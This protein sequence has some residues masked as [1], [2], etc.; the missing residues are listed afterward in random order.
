MKGHAGQVPKGLSARFSFVYNAQKKGT[1]ML[2]H[3]L[4]VGL[5]GALG[6]VARAFVASVMP[7]SAG[8]LPL[9]IL[10]INIIGCFLMAVIM[11]TDALVWTMP[12]G[13][14]TFLT[15]GFLGGFTTFSAFALEWGLLQ[16]KGLTLYG[17][18]YVLASVLFSLLA[19]VIG[20]RLVR[21][22]A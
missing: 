17:I 22:M 8:P 7:A 15:T 21:L 13:V 5:G 14:R 6:A 1:Q 2:S 20:M 16:E 11:E 19:F 9:P 3:Y 4:V 12:A 18:A 10:L